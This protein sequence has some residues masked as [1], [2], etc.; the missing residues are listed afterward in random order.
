MNKIF[1]QNGSERMLDKANVLG[2]FRQVAFYINIE[3]TGSM[4]VYNRAIQSIVL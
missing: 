2:E 4:F 3:M 1:Y